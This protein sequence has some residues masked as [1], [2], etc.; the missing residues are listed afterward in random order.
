MRVTNLE[1]G[2]NKEE[3]EEDLSKFIYTS[4]QSSWSCDP[5]EP[6]RHWLVV[7]QPDGGVAPVAITYTNCCHRYW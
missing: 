2:K 3:E 5:F 4:Y 7:C 1:K 6:L